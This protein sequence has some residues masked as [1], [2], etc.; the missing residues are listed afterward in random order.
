ME[1]SIDEFISICLFL[2]RHKYMYTLQFFRLNQEYTYKIIYVKQYAVKC[3]NTPV[4]HRNMATV[5]FSWNQFCKHGQQIKQYKNHKLQSK[6]P[7]AKLG[8]KPGQQ[9]SLLQVST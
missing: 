5:N 9:L 3:C 8:N 6:W 1:R 7:N 2:L 4:T